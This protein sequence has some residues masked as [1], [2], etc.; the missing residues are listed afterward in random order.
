VQA[1]GRCR[2]VLPG[3][4]E[5]VVVS[6]EECGVEL[7][8]RG[9]LLDLA[10]GAGVAR[11][12][13]VM[14][15]GIQ[16]DTK[17]GNIPP[18]EIGTKPYK[19]SSREL[20][21]FRVAELAERLQVTPR[22]VRAW[23]A[24]A[25]RRGLVVKVRNGV[26]VA[27]R[28]RETRWR[29]VPPAADL[30]GGTMAT[31]PPD[32]PVGVASLALGIGATVAETPPELPVGVADVTPSPAHIPP[33]PS[34]PVPPGAATSCWWDRPLPEPPEPLDWLGW[35][36]GEPVGGDV[37]PAEE[38]DGTASPKPERNVRTEGGPEGRG[39]PQT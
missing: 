37:G 19:Q 14:S 35:A 11:L 1:V 16:A 36:L 3:G 13:A 34:S 4:L 15:G 18:V 26:V 32:L 12:L 24:V 21:Q 8:D 28:G 29:L 25:E 39:R 22:A 23:L 9:E 33:P 38:A 20:C 30:E 5:G 27:T 31:P 6:S 17:D 10:R 7:A 2:S